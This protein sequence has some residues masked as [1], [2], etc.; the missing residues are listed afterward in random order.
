MRRRIP[1]FVSILAAFF[2]MGNILVLS[3]CNDKEDE[4]TLQASQWVFPEGFLFGTAIA[5]FQAD[6]GC[7]TLAPEKCDEKNSDWYAYATDEFAIKKGIGTF[8]SGDDPT[9]V[10]PG[11]WELYR[12]DLQL[13]AQELHNNAFRTSVEWSRLFPTATDDVEGYDALKAIANAD[14]I[15]TYH[16]M[17]A[18][19]RENGLEPFITLN[20]YSLPLWIHDVLAC[21][22]VAGCEDKGW[23]DRE[24]I[25]KE[26]A[27]FAG[28][29]AKEFGADV[30][31]WATLNEPMA[32]IFPGYLQPGE[33][34][35]NPPAK[36][37]A[38]D[39]ART[40]LTA[41]AE[42][43][44]RMYDAVKENDTTDASGDGKAAEV[45]V[46]YNLT[47]F[48]GRDE[49]KALD[50]AGAENGFYLWNLVFLNAVCKGELDEMWDGNTVHREDMEN[51][52]DFFGL[53]YY[54][55]WEVE[56]T[57]EVVLPDL[58]PKTTF[59][60]LTVIT[61][62][63]YPKG[64]YD[65]IM[66]IHKEYGLPVYITESGTEPKA[67]DPSYIEGYLVHHLRW[68][69]KAV[70][71]GADVRG[72]FYW[73]FMDNFEWN[74]GMDMKLG[75]YEVK[76]DDPTKARI[77]RNSATIFS[78]ISQLKALPKKAVEAHPE[79]DP[80]YKFRP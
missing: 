66:F 14:A 18:A 7:P 13:A 27:K 29:V 56:G 77:P 54:N 43:H 11:F 32:V 35:S 6:M 37:L 38:F 79:E 4:D 70:E 25:V 39:E 59:N 63:I 9:K 3:G 5:G 48:V 2:L 26:I 52:I 24:R 12:Q 53:N 73:T 80:S 33:S 64:M 55:L 51:R 8:L 50:K 41:M 46:V 47:P 60:L 10:G 42:A 57:G 34:R 69:L 61:D 44:A 45:G 67:N 78:Q 72:Y 68:L 23:P 16:D 76:P 36:M 1:N 31:L 71:E 65:S 49:T 19:M 58:S 74:H 75:L 17:F 15:A 22:T 21:R 40:G 20:H 30:D 28:F 62:Y